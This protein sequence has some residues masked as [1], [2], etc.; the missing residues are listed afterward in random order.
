MSPSQA[1]YTAGAIL[2]APLHGRGRGGCALGGS[3]TSWIT[4]PTG[5]SG[6][7]QGFLPQGPGWATTS[8]SPGHSVTSTD[9]KVV[10]THGHP[11]STPPLLPS[12]AEPWIC[13][14]ATGSDLVGFPSPEI[15]PNLAPQPP[16]PVTEWIRSNKLTNKLGKTYKVLVPVSR[17]VAK[18][19]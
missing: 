15:K 8:H 13:A 14:A 10:D 16:S 1:P 12:L 4:Q 11:P 17:E 3:S 9:E 19:E 6:S 5:S 2:T 18:E 7:E